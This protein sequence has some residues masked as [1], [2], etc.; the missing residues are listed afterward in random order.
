MDYLLKVK[1]EELEDGQDESELLDYEA[2]ESAGRRGYGINIREGFG[3]LGVVG[4]ASG[5]RNGEPI[6]NR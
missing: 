5:I 2:I 1:K 3:D 4:Q 6:S